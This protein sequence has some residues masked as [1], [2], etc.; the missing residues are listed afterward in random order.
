MLARIGDVLPR[1]RIYERLYKDHERLLV[2]LSH[3]YL[4]IL[5]FCVRTKDFFLNAKRSMS[6]YTDVEYRVPKAYSLSVPLSI[7]LKAAWKP[8]RQDFDV[9]MNAFRMHSKQIEQEARL[10]HRIESARMYEIQLANRAL[11]IRNSKLQKRHDLLSVLPSIDYLGKHSRFQRNKHP[12][13]NAWL[14]NTSQYTD[15]LSSQGSDCLCCYGI[16]GSGKSI[17]ASSVVEDLTSSLLDDS[18]IVCQYYCD[19]ADSASLDPYCLAGSLLKQALQSISLDK[20]TDEFQCP[21]IEGK[22]APSFEIM[23]NYLM[24]TLQDFRTVYIVLDGIDEIAQENQQILLALINDM[25]RKH[26][27][28]KIFVTS[29]TEEYWIRKVMDTHRNVHL[30]EACT[31]SDITLFIQDHLDA[32]SNSGPLSAN[33]GLKEKVLAAL[34][35]GANGM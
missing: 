31:K 35:E 27:N 21:F 2:A 12:G 32:A 7:V 8:F 9:H 20:F 15:W 3:A 16:P 6:R 1:F 4:D 19:Y 23:S 34:V 33:E 25:L 24:E 28:L 22:P 11:Q 29:R 30:S 18:S 26:S 10:A 17:L 14:K 13:T 5:R